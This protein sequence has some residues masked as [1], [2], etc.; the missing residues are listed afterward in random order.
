[1]YPATGHRTSHMA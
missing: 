1:M